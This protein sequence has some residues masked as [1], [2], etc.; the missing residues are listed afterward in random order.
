VDEPRTLHRYAPNKWSVK[1][2]VQHLVDT[3]RVF[4]SRALA[5]A[6]GDATELPGFDENAYAAASHADDRVL[7][8]I[9]EE[10][11]AVRMASLA[12]FTGLADEALTR[13]GVADGKPYS[14]RAIPWIV[15]GHE[16]HHLAVLRERYLG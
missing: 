15:V 5:F 14:V 7:E 16:L 8:E 4:S 12:L 6:R 2:L 11:A 13:R 1:E 3:E 10:H 9:L